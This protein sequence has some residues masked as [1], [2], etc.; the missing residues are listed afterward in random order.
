MIDWIINT[1][2]GGG[3]GSQLVQ[4]VKTIVNKISPALKGGNTK[5]EPRKT[6]C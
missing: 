6:P 2:S 5:H 3:G 4:H 1:L